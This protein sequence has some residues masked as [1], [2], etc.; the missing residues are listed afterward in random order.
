MEFGERLRELRRK[1]GYTQSE[2]ADKANI[3][4]SVVSFYEHK[5]RAPSPD[6]LKRFAEVFDVSTDFLLGVKRNTPD[7]L[8]VSGLS[9]AEIEAL[10]TIVESM[11]G[12][13]KQ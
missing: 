3:T 12:K 5:D 13:K 6:V 1:C 8:D 11:K 2:L 4:K 10:Q 7:T 9:E